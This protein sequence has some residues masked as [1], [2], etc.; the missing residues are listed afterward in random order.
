MEDRG[1]TMLESGLTR[2][3]RFFANRL[4]AGYVGARGI[5]QNGDLIAWGSC[6]D[7]PGK[8]AGPATGQGGEVEIA[9]RADPICDDICRFFDSGFCRR[10]PASR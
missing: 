7:Y 1:V 8:K 2:A 4:E 5:V 10:S 9:V 6:A 3:G